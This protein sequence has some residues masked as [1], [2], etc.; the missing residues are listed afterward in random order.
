[1]DNLV[2]LL[3]A[4]TIIWG[5]V[6]GYILVIYRRQRRLRQEV[7]DLRARMERLKGD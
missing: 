5:L 6:F 7:A 4:Y 2:Y 1:M 3:A